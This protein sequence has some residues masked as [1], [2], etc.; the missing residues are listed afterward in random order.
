M[1]TRAIA[2]TIVFAALSIALTPIAIPAGF[3]GFFYRF[4]EI[5]IVAAFLLF[6]PKVGV[7]VA[8][9]RTLAELTLFQGPIPGVLGFLGAL[10]ALGGTLSMLLGVHVASWLL[11]RK[12]AQDEDSGIKSGTY[13]TVLGGL[14]R[15]VI[16][17][18]IM[19]PVWHFLIPKP[20]SDAVIIGLV[21]PLMLFAFTLCLYT[22][23]IGYLIATMV[24]KALAV[25]KRL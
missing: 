12:T 20:L 1:D 8:V 6:G 7:T 2:L 21:P 15:M 17:P 16:V 23:P 19:Y 13:C 25:G 22:I 11:K 4:W 18:F 14:S 24:N 10:A 3:I 5:P 9:L